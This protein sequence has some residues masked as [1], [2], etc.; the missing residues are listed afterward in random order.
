M[1]LRYRAMHKYRKKLF[2]LYSK[3]LKIHCVLQNVTV[4]YFSQ[5]ASYMF[6]SALVCLELVLNYI[7]CSWRRGQLVD[8]EFTYF[9]RIL[10]NETIHWRRVLVY[11][12]ITFSFI[13]FVA[14]FLFVRLFVRS[15]FNF[16][17]FV[18]RLVLT[19]LYISVQI[20]LVPRLYFSLFVSVR[21]LRSIISDVRTMSL[22]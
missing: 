12:G 21:Y 14:R 22:Q 17:C 13:I 15:N 5:F 4:C 3:K 20:I 8:S 9:V 10:H 7:L 2:I 19:Y 1:E 16:V 11:T 6:T 18:I